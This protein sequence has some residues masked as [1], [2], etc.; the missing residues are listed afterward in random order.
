MFAILNKCIHE[1]HHGDKNL[2]ELILVI[3][4]FTK[5]VESMTT[6]QLQSIM[7]FL[8]VCPK[9]RHVIEVTNPNTKVKGEVVVGGPPNFLG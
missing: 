3:K 4:R 9:L 6:G 8:T 2:Q 7:N 1:I 5:F